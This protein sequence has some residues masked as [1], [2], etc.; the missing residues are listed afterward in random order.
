MFKCFLSIININKTNLIFH[1]TIKIISEILNEAQS[2]IKNLVW[3]YKNTRN[4]NIEKN[5]EKFIAQNE[6]IN[7]IYK[8]IIP[9]KNLLFYF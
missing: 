8:L 2:H 9:I 1:P 4:E 6:P 3:Q 5:G 7:E